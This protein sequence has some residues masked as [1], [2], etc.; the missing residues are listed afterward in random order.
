VIAEEGVGRTT[1]QS[2]KDKAKRVS[3]RCSN[4]TLTP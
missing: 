3:F 1:S 4:A 2:P